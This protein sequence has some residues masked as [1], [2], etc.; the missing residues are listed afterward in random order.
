MIQFINYFS[1]F[2]FNWKLA[3]LL[4]LAH[5]FEFSL[6]VSRIPIRMYSKCRKQIPQYC[7]SFKLQS[8]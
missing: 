8:S 5:G 4:N 6:L 3:W 1:N 2:F 7:L